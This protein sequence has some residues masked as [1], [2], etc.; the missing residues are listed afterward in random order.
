M[1]RLR[2]SLMIRRAVLRSTTTQTT[3]TAANHQRYM[4]TSVP[5]LNDTAPSMTAPPPQQQQQPSPPPPPN[6]TTNTIKWTTHRL[7]PASIE[8]VDAIFH[9]ILWLDLIETSLLTES[10]NHKLGMKLSPKQRAALERHLEAMGGGSQ[11]QHDD[12]DAASQEAAAAPTGPQTVDIR[13]TGFD[14]QAKIKVIK[15]VRSLVA[16]LG[17]KE[18]KELVE[19]APT[20]ILKDCKPDV[21][22]EMQ[23]KLQEL[24]ATVELVS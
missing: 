1:N 12:K 14:P 9:K 21:A 16:G 17:L 13:L 20:T 7:S 22:Q 11:Q 8:K 2:S 6:N 3:T 18:A 19:G 15:Q 23:K 10:I 4:H 5:R 24:G